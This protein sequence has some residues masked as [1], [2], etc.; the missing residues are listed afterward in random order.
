[1]HASTVS[2][3]VRHRSARLVDGTT[4]PLRRLFGAHHDV[5]AAVAEL[6]RRE[7]RPSDAAIAAALAEQGHHIAR[8][9]VAK[10]RHDLSR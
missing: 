9:T 10:Y 2:R 3:A 4:V 7:P 6:V 5:R 8:R 1:V